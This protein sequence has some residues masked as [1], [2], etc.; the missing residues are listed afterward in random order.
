MKTYVAEIDGEAILA[1]RAENDEAARRIIGEEDAGLEFVLRGYSGL[2]RADGRV[3]WDG[4]SPIRH[5]LASPQEHE[6][7]LTLRSARLGS[8]DDPDDW[9]VYLVPVR[10]IDEKGGDDAQWISSQPLGR[11]GSGE[12]D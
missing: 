5:R 2:L 10:S 9:V 7:W 3:L 11:A 4:T 1:F 12:W 6:L 8:G